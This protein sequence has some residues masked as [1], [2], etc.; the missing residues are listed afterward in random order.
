MASSTRKKSESGFY[1]VV[2]RGVNHFDIFESDDDRISYLEILQEVAST[3]G[4]EIYVWCLMSNHTHLLL[5]A[6][7]D[8]LVATMRKLGSVYAKYFNKIH[9]RSGPLFEGRFRSVCV[10]TDEQLIAVVRYIHRNP[11]THEETA[12][13]GD[14]AWSSYR[15]YVNG[16]D[17]VCVKSFILDLFGGLNGFLRIHN[18][19]WPF[20]RHLDID[21]AGRMSDEEARIMANLVL[22]QAG[23]DV[24]ISQIGTLARDARD[25]AICL[26]KRTVGC[27][28]RQL[29]RLSAISL[30]V[31]CSA[32][33]AWLPGDT[34]TPPIDP[35][36]E[37]A[38]AFVRKLCS[39][40]SEM[41]W[42]GTGFATAPGPAS[43]LK[44]K[45]CS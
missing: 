21:T 15:E 35:P 41:E 40:A 1:H 38:L 34:C 5:K 32:M 10:E 9:G 44:R 14:Y 30:S 16:E 12:L 39:S 31:I 19:E 20:E 2:Q 11:I 36:R 24:S 3:Y 18:E 8:G 4:A 37:P 33:K 26:V 45:F 6:S 17:G 43:P 42:R 7:L 22:S 25:K 29:R 23:I 28:V 27:S 13:A